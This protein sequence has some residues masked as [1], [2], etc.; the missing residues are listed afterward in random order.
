M[1]FHARYSIQEVVQDTEKTR[2]K[3]WRRMVQFGLVFFPS[4]IDVVPF[5]RAISEASKINPRMK[6]LGVDAVPISLYP[7]TWHANDDA[8]NFKALSKG[9]K[10]FC[11]PILTKLILDREPRITLDW[12][13]RVCTR[14]ADV[15]RVIP[16]H[17]NNNVRVS[18]SKDFYDA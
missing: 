18:S 2:K 7:W 14:F 15:K 10:L 5:D 16:C 6:L 12:V 17:L 1:L 9:G 11:P 13:D 3:G 4:Q 8:K